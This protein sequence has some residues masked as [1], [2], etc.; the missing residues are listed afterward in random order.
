MMPQQPGT[1]GVVVL[2]SDFKALGVVRSLGRRGIPSIIIDNL[3]RSAWFSRYIV[4]QFRWHGP[5]DSTS[6]LNFLLN[7][8][9]EYH[10]EQWVLFPV[11]DEVVELVA[12][13]NQQLAGIY[14]LVTQEWEI[15][16]WAI[17]KC[18]TYRMA[19]EM[20]VPYPKTWYPVNED[21]LRKL[22]ISFPVIV[23]PAISIHLQQAMRLKALFASN[24]AE[25]LTQYRLAANIMHPQE[26][27][28]QEFIPSDGHDRTQFSV[29][30][31]CKEGRAIIRMTARRTRQYPIDFGLS[32]TFVEA[33]EVPALF[34]PAEKLL[35]YMRVSGM[36]E[37]EFK[38]DCRDEQYKLLDINVRPWAWHTLCIACGLDFPFIQ[39]CDVL[40]QA[41]VSVVPCYG[42]YHWVRLLTDLPAGLQEMR[43][44]ITT[45]WAYFH[46]LLGKTVFAVF[47]WSDPLP[48]LGDFIVALSR[49][50][51]GFHSRDTKG[52]IKP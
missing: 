12:R 28:I 25:L 10:L 5:M 18:L 39:Y 29:A 27:M 9:K 45:P 11:Q 38:Y 48:A 3:P 4:K 49:S 16:Q 13:N 31:Y 47:D 34:E 43:A 15:V 7:I 30:T 14:R 23:K 20:D 8:G 44:G 24:Y 21:D 17:D 32:S 40:E 6:F 19:Q 41:P 22:E 46:S 36:V 1:H 42:N 51:K 37:I 35:R 26:I 52:R 2:G 50:I 33:V